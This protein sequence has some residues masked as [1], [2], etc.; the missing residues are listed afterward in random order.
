MTAEYKFQSILWLINGERIDSNG[1]LHI[2]DVKMST[3]IFS[4]SIAKQIFH[5]L[6]CSHE[7]TSAM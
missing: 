1:E 7:F 4:T 6:K 3:S 5:T 2:Q